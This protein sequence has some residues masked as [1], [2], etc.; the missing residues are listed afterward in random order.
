MTGKE[1]KKNSFRFKR[2]EIREN[3]T[4]EKKENLRNSHCV[5]EKEIRAL[6]RDVK[7]IDDGPRYFEYW[8]RNKENTLAD[9]QFSEISHH[10][11]V[12][13]PSEIWPAFSPCAS[14][15]SIDDFFGDAVFIHSENVV[16]RF[17]SLYFDEINYV[18]FSLLSD[19]GR[20]SIFFAAFH[21]PE[22]LGK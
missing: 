9:P 7:A 3:S 1:N 20:N 15:F 16:F 22:F 13:D 4:Q 19:K 2:N 10:A 21:F 5:P 6:Y 12:I 14:W 11:N 8:L 18:R 17:N